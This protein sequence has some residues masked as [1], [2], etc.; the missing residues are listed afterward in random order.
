MSNDLVIEAKGLTRLYG[1]G[2]AARPAIEDVSLEVK[3]GE[4]VAVLGPSGCGK[5]TLLGIL[6]CLDRAFEG[7]LALFG[8]DTTTMSDREQAKLRGTKI[9]F[10]F[11]AFHLLGHLS[12]RDNV[13]SPTLFV[14]HPPD[15]DLGA[16]A[17]E[18]LAAVGLAG[19]GDDMPATMSG[20]ERQRLAIA[21]ALLMKPPLL[22]CDEPTG[23][24]DL[25][26]GRNVTDI[27]RRLHGE[28][29]TIVAVTHEEMLAGAA[30]RTVRLR[31]GRVVD[32]AEGEG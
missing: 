17:E 3:E 25:E 29:L 27:F 18:L 19:R 2:K 21:R 30:E 32:E 20:G 22:L 11:Q 9:G 7:S 6:G 5:S 10:V 26:T 31:G 24:L 14:D 8:R 23:N 16:R 4:F 1:D 28:G 12:A 15:G 13:L